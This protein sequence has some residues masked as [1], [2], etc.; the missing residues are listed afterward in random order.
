MCR[1]HHESACDDL[2]ASGLTGRMRR[3]FITFRSTFPDWREEI[4]CLV[5]EDD[6]VAGRFEC[7]RTHRGEF[8]E[9]SPTGKRQEVGEVFFLYVEGGRFVD[10]WSLKDTQTRMRQL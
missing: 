8:L 6:M 1:R 5:S 2:L 7:H 10:M 9:M 3:D 4:A